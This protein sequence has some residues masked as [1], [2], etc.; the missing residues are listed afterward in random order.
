MSGNYER[1]IDAIKSKNGGSVPSDL[2]FKT[3][4]ELGLILYN[5]TG[6]VSIF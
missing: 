3:N 2:Y 5:L 4:S 1:A 6:T